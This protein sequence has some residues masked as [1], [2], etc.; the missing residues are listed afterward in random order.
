MDFLG[1][2]LLQEGV[3]PDLKKLE[4]IWDWKKPV[5]VKGI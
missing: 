3:R 4:A 1:H 2:I 5:I